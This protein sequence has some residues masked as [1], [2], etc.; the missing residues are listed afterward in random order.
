MTWRL[1]NH[2]GLSEVQN[3]AVHSVQ[4]TQLATAGQC[5]SR[6]NLWLVTVPDGLYGCADTCN[7][8]TAVTCHNKAACVWT[9]DIG[10]TKGE[11]P[12]SYELPFRS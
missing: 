7:C 12:Q 10:C 4:V 8:A 9:S 1:Y 11:R 3:Y 2:N 5:I 6:S